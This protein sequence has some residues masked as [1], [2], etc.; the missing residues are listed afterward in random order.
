MYV[1]S[2]VYIKNGA[3]PA[4]GPREIYYFTATDPQAVNAL[5]LNQYLPLRAAFLSRSCVIYAVKSALVG[6]AKSS[7]LKK[8]VTP[9]VGTT[10]VT[11]DIEASISAFG[12]TAARDAK[13]MFHFRGIDANWI[14]QDALVPAY[15]P[16]LSYISAQLLPNGSLSGQGFLDV[17]M[18]N[19][20]MMPVQNTSIVNGSQISAAAKPTQGAL[21]TLTV[22]V[23]YNP[24]PGTL[25]EITGCKQSNLLN[26]KWLTTGP[27]VAGSIVLQGS[28]NF[29]APAGL[30]G[31][32]RSV[33][34]VT[35]VIT[36][37][38]Y[39]GISSKKTGR[40]SFLQ[41]GR[42]SAKIHR[43]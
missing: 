21:I 1:Q 9:I 34:P 6:G 7:W 8:L 12:F 3:G 2:T 23:G 43:R 27:Q 14:T 18:R 20:L 17:L 30:T 13:R 26:A 29:S 35:G 24:A 28:Q 36:N 22:P 41:R 15:V 16:K 40:P 11:E 37:L 33:Q 10:G 39:N 42:Q 5:W 31:V 38:E 19:G 4:L 25:V 32:I